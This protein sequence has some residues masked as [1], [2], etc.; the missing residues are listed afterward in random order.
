MFDCHGLTLSL[1]LNPFQFPSCLRREF[2]FLKNVESALL[3]EASVC[4]LMTEPAGD[5][6]VFAGGFDKVGGGK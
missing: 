3:L 4:L 5:A 1:I 6:E 2:I